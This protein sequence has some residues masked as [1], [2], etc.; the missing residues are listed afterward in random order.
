MAMLFIATPILMAQSVGDFG[1]AASGNWTDKGGTVDVNSNTIT[2]GVIEEFSLWTAGAGVVKPEFTTCEI[3]SSR[4]KAAWGSITGDLGSGFEMTLDPVVDFYYLNFSATTATNVQVKEGY[5]GFTIIS[6]PEGFFEYWAGRGV[7]ATAEAGTWQAEAWKIINGELPTFYVNS[8]GAGVLTLVDGLVKAIGQPDEYLRIEGSYLIGDYSYRG[9]IT[10][11]E[12]AVSDLMV[13]NITFSN[14][15]VSKPAVF[16]SEYIEGSSNN[17]ALEIYNNTGNAVDLSR[18]TIK[19]ANNG[20]GWGCVGGTPD[21]RYVLPLT[22]SLAA[23]DVFVVYNTSADAAIVAVGDLGKAYNSTANGGDGDNVPAFNGDD[24][25]GLFYGDSLIDVIGVPT[26]DPGTNWPV[27]G[28]GATSE[29]TLVRKSSVVTGN[30]NWTTSS[31][32]SATDSEW[33]VYPRDTFGYLGEHPTLIVKPAFTTC[34]IDSSTD[35]AAWGSINGNLGT[36]FKMTLDPAVDMY[37]LNFGPTTATNVT[38]KAGYYGFTIASHPNGFFE[39]WAGR[40]VVESAAA[41]TWQAEAWK[42]INGNLPTFYVASDGAG[43]LMLVDG[44]VKAIGQPDE[45]LRIEGN[46]LLGAYSYKGKITA[47]DDTESDSITVNITFEAPLE[48]TTIAEIQDTTGTGNGDSKLKGQTVLTTGIVTAAKTDAYFIQDKTGP[49][50]G[51]YVYDSGRVPV[52]GDSIVIECTVAEY[53]NLTE[54]ATVTKYEIIASGKTLPEP[55]LLSTADYKQEQ[56]EGVL[57]TV[58]NAE[59][60]STGKEWEVNDG[61]GLGRIDDLLFAFTPKIGYSY[62]VTGPVNYSYNNFMVTPRSADDIVEYAPD[63]VLPLF[64]GATDGTLDLEWTFDPWG[65]ISANHASLT[66]VDSSTNAWGSHVIAFFDSSYTGIAEVARASFTDYTISS[67]IYIV[68][69]ADANFNLYTGLAIMADSNK[70]YRFVYRNSSASDNGQLKLQG[71]DGA[72]WHIS[73]NWNPGTDFTALA[74]GWHNLKVTKMGNN[75]WVSVDGTELP[76]CPLRDEDPFMTEGAPGIYKYNTGVGTVLFDNFTVVEPEAAFVSIATAARD[77]D[78]DL[79]SDLIGKYVT[80]QGIITT[81]NLSYNANATTGNYERCDYFIQDETGGIN[82]YSFNFRSEFQP[83]DLLTVTGKI[84]TYNGK[85]EIIPD[86]ANDI[87]VVSTGNPLPEPKEISLADVNSETYEGQLVVVKNLHPVKLSAWPVMDSTYSTNYDKCYATDGSSDTVQVFIDRQTEVPLWE[88]LRYYNFDL[89]GVVAQYSKAVPPNTGYEIIPRFVDDITCH[90]PTEGFETE[91]VES[92]ETAVPPTG[93]YTFVSDLD[94]GNVTEPWTRGNKAPSAGTYHAYMNNYNS[95]SYCWLVSPALSTNSEKNVLSFVAF[96]EANTTAN[97]FGSEL[98]VMAAT[99]SGLFLDQ[100]TEVKRITEAECV[101][102]H[103]VWTI[104]LPELSDTNYVYIAFMVHNFGDPANPN[105]GGD[106]W[107][108]DDVRMTVKEGIRDEALPMVFALHQ[109]YPNPFNPTTMIK[110]DLPKE[111]NVK[112]VIYDL[113]GR[114]VRTLVSAKQAA[115]YK[116]IQ[117]DS[118]NNSG[119]LVSSGY[120]ICVMNAGDFHKNIKMVLI[121]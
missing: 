67:D 83:G 102:T 68:G 37:Y 77:N 24:A 78:G 86:S 3:D 93:W 59:C 108:I 18:Y 11:T 76:G 5:Y 20:T 30:T 112:L 101:G 44:L 116:A 14:P 57:V 74:T 113:M 85:N 110:Y 50:N 81:P 48:L 55:V 95:G 54:L 79:K 98:V 16:F 89:V 103:P 29:Y 8:D 97:D 117:W 7:V 32:T 84:D 19:A 105:V 38:I 12:N 82:L 114:E 27:A 58:D 22:G 100:W 51:V 52:V 21:T 45:F 111:S 53:Y 43:V 91:M 36:G 65:M 13:V 70:Y 64:E 109:N 119:R 87:L 35:K 1:S 56:W 61:S 42:I 107:I 94:S 96:D 47:A 2:S 60:V 120:Y 15:V 25:I 28:T 63:I 17:K 75:F 23:G 41:G 31:G 6:H 80:V 72:S 115:G 121:K 33:E 26:T 10:S 73:K 49:W 4:D 69:P 92:F 46:Y 71:Y 118:K 104:D 40:G 88:G 99:E 90:V 34:E 66:V 39:Y 9:Q 62:K 106:N